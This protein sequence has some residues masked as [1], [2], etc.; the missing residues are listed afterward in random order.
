MRLKLARKSKTACLSALQTH[1]ED[2][3]RLRFAAETHSKALKLKIL[4]SMAEV[5][6]HQAQT[7]QT[8]EVVQTEH[9]K[10]LCKGLLLEWKNLAIEKI[11]RRDSLL[12]RQQKLQARRFFGKLR[13]LTQIGF[14]KREVNSKLLFFRN[15]CLKVKA[16]QSLKTYLK[17]EDCTKEKQARS[18]SKKLLKSR[19]LKALRI[20]ATRGSKLKFFLQRH[21]SQV[22]QNFLSK[23]LNA[24]DRITRHKQIFSDIDIVVKQKVYRALKT[25]WARR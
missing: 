6:H 9:Y 25:H 24:I 3:I 20:C 12:Q 8:Y 10:K 18:L 17:S 15:N 22:K 7:D 1:A 16:M 23:W 4:K 21:Q 13:L 14:V 11:Q 2:K 19:T 5:C